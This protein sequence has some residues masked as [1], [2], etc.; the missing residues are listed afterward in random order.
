MRKKFNGFI[1]Q[2]G[3]IWRFDDWAIFE[4]NKVFAVFDPNRGRIVYTQKTDTEMQYPIRTTDKRN[5]FFTNQHSLVQLSIPKF[6]AGMLFSQYDRG[7]MVKMDTPAISFTPLAT[8]PEE[9]LPD[10]LHKHLLYYHKTNGTIGCLN[11][12]TN[13]LLWERKY[14]KD[15]MTIIGPHVNGGLL[16][17]LVSYSPDPAKEETLGKIIA[18][19]SKNGEAAWLSRDLYFKNFAPIQF[20]KYILSGNLQHSI[21]L[22]DMKTGRPVQMLETE[23]LPSQP[24]TNQKSV[25]IMTTSKIYRF[26]QESL[27]ETIRNFFTP[28]EP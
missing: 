25:F 9:I 7:K 18:V 16:F 19:K 27:W 17:Y 23:G 12:K 10:T 4:K 20:G 26:D 1:E 22:L 5:L 21:L 24:V 8:L 15:D 13:Q 2:R 28:Q 3:P 6:A 14:F 11:I